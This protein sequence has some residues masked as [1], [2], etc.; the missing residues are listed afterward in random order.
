MLENV[1]R[2]VFL[3]VLRRCSSPSGFLLVK[4]QPFQLGLDLQGGTRLVYSVDFD[5]AR[6]DERIGPGEDEDLVLDQMIQI[7][8]NRI[9]PRGTIEP[10]IR[11]GGGNRI[12]IELPGTL[13]LPRVDP[14][15]RHSTLSEPLTDGE[16]KGSHSFDPDPRKRTRMGSPRAASSPSAPSRSATTSKEGNSILLSADRQ[17]RTACSQAH[18]ADAAVEAR[19]AT[20]PSGRPS[21]AS[22]SSRSASWPSRRRSRHASIDTDEASERE[23][24][25]LWTEANP[26][27]PAR[28]LQ[29]PEVRE[30]GPAP[31]TSSSIRTSSPR[32][33][34][35]RAFGA[36]SE[37]TS[38]WMV[39]KPEERRHGLPRGRPLARLPVAGR[40][41]LSPRSASRCAPQRRS[42]FGHFT[43]DNQN[44]LMAIVLNEEVSSAPRIDEHPARGRHHPGPLHEPG[45]AGPDDG[46]ALG[47]AQDQTELEIRR[48]RRR[49]P[50]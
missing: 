24:L 26:D 4:D 37:L 23:K 35:R 30:R 39:L 31:A 14:V 18:D 32:T 36:G 34:A 10:S 42:D 8:R 17:R 21:R 49:D 22:A 46:P 5:A 12:V 40:P 33:S 47:L 1:G 28:R 15:F 45:S 27:A 41:R 9:D 2:K 48:A 29:P 6:K 19:Q 44:R 3:I 16:V 25:R 50:R 43:G 38:T 13:G 20:T 7:I 11:R